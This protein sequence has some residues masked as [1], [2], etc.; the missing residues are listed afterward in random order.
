VLHFPTVKRSLLYCSINL[1]YRLP[2]VHT[3]HILPHQLQPLLPL[4]IRFVLRQHEYGPRFV[5]VAVDV[6]FL[7]GQDINVIYFRCSKFYALN[8]SIESFIS[9]LQPF[10][11]PEARSLLKTY[12]LNHLRF[13]CVAT[14]AATVIG[15]ENA[16]SCNELLNVNFEL[17]WGTK[18]E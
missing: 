13:V 5:P 9:L 8:R 2:P 3:L 16:S 17:I 15:V 11:I 1:V 10:V 12:V 14:T 18:V 7:L 6:L 4:C